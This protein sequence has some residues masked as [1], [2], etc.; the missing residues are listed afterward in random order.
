MSIILDA[1]RKADAQRKRGAVPDIHSSP[2]LE[3]TRVERPG[4]PWIGIGVV[5]ALMLVAAALWTQGPWLG[6]RPQAA[7]RVNDAAAGVG[8]ALDPS[9]RRMGPGVTAGANG[10]N[11]ASG[12]AGVAGTVSAP[13]TQPG[14]NVSG[15]TAASGP[16]NAPTGPNASNAPNVPNVPNAQN[17][18]NAPVAPTAPGAAARAGA[19]SPAPVAPTVERVLAL[20]ELPDNIRRELPAFNVTGAMHSEVRADRVL[21]VSGRLFHEGDELVA[22]CVLEEI[23]PRAAVL[24]YRGLRFRLTW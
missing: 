9:R 14:Q 10:G 16:V 13:A 19:A 3:P 7:A 6:A 2:T 21:I 22:G 8:G 5:A 15:A 24:S 4:P 18:Q 17:A 1:L 12:A 11:G 23:Q 20:N